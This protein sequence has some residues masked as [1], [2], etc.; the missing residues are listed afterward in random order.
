MDEMPGVLANYLNNQLFRNREIIH[1]EIHSAILL[2]TM[3][4]IVR[5]ISTQK[6]R[7]ICWI[8]NGIYEN[9]IKKV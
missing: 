1:Q 2:E 3:P 8:D 4:K 9:Q 5:S 7:V 6:D